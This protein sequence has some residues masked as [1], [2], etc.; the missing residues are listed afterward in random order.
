MH[1]C[2]SCSS[3][4]GIF[5]VIVML[6]AL[7]YLAATGVL[8]ERVLEINTLFPRVAAY[9]TSLNIII[10][11]P[12]TGLGFGISTFLDAKAEY[13]T[14]FGLVPLQWTVFA[15]VPHNDF[16][17]LLVLTGL[18]GFIPF[19]IILYWALKL[20]N[21]VRLRRTG[22]EQWRI[23]LGIYLN[24]IFIAYLATSMIVDTLFFRYFL[25]LVYFLLGVLV[26]AG[27]NEP[28]GK[29][30]SSPVHAPTPRGSERAART[31]S[32]FT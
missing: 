24:A 9:A 3:G 16:L 15:G 27:S 25:M 7:P 17:H 12:L 8:Q 6:A 20:S 21:P 11:N 2:A 30:T 4:G 14:T 5:S 29:K 26:S 13:A 31:G 1:E 22:A 10:H 32:D 28:V 18:A 19:V 23:E